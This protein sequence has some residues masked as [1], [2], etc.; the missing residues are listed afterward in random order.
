MLRR[1]FVRQWQ[2]EKPAVGLYSVS[3]AP[4]HCLLTNSSDTKCATHRRCYYRPSAERLHALGL[5]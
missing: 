4:D 3:W 5:L 1:W 2:L